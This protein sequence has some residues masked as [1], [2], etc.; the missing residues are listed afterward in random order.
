MVVSLTAC[1]LDHSK[2]T[3]NAVTQTV[4]ASEG[5]S[6][7]KAPGGNSSSHAIS[8]CHIEDME[9]RWTTCYWLGY[10]AACYLPRK[11]VKHLHVITGMK[12]C[13]NKFVFTGQPNSSI[14]NHTEQCDETE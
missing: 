3:R 6:I 4:N 12:C 5:W 13:A 9:Q 7:C 2:Q 14:T 10:Y 8:R 11:M 1:Q